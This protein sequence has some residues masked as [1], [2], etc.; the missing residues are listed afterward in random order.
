MAALCDV[1]KATACCVVMVWACAVLS[2]TN[3][4]QLWIPEGFAH[5][6]VSTCEGTEVHYKATAFWQRDCERALRWDDPQLAIDWGL[7]RLDFSAPLL[8][9]KD[10]LAPLLAQ[11]HDAGEVFA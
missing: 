3:H 1:V 7:E 2:A 10:A 9:S 6:F 5:G 4:Q 11:A 8:T